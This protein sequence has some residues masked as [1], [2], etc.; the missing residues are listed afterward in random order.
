MKKISL[1]PLSILFI[2]LWSCDNNDKS[3]VEEF[4][5]PNFNA[6]Y[7]LASPIQLETDST[8]IRIKDFIPEDIEITNIT[9]HEALKHSFSADSS[10]L[11]LKIVSDDLPK[12]SFLDIEL[13][14][15]IESILLKKSN[16]IKQQFT[17][18]PRRKN[19]FKSSNKRGIQCM[20]SQTVLN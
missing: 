8:I 11:Y 7:G 1:I 15:H 10:L 2:F 18:D 17:F 16:K 9:V 19:L 6:I 4:K 13:G 3:E 14:W 12:L 20:E 5:L